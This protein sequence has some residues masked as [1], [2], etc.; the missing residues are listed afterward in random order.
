MLHFASRLPLSRV[1]LTVACASALPACA[2]QNLQDY[3]QEDD[4]PYAAVC[5]KAQSERN[6]AVAEKTYLQPMFHAHVWNTEPAPNADQRLHENAVLKAL[7]DGRVK[8]AFVQAR[9]GIGKTEFAR[10]LAASECRDLP[11]FLLDFKE[12]AKAGGTEQA[13]VQ[14]IA[15]QTG[16]AP[17]D[18]FKLLNQFLLKERFLLIVDSLDEVSPGQ[19]APVLS[20][21]VNLR[22]QF[23]GAQ[24]VL[25][26][27]PA[28]YE[29]Y[30]G[31]AG[32][33]AF[34]E[35]DPLDCTKAMSAFSLYVKDAEASKRVYGFVKAWGLDREGR[36]GDRCYH[37]FLSTYRDLQA[38]TRMAEKFDESKDEMG[39]I[40]FSTTQVHEEILAER[41]KKELGEL[42]MSPADLWKT[43]DNILNKDGFVGGEWNLAMTIQRCLAAQPGGDNGRNR[44]LCEELFQSVLFERVGGNLGSVAEAEW[45]FG[46]QAQADLFTSRWL[47]AEL[48]KQNGNCAMLDAHSVMFDGSK[49][50]AGYLVGRPHGG[51]CLAK[52]AQLLCKAKP[53]AKKLHVKQLYRGL[54]PGDARRPLVSA[55]KEAAAKS[56]PDSCTVDVLGAL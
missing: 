23:A 33:D 37:P 1:A 46:N 13:V 54:P 31:I 39:G 30:Y 25:L 40:Q 3:V 7:R 17:G 53:D 27:R 22:K 24:I 19:R 34:L 2:A 8:T 51:K 20:A 45:K 43:V 48:G 26:G 36:A 49:E 16:A 47:D 41:V 6:R 52:V 35:L 38:I 11:S 4:R 15:K 32:F 42:G 29:T 14:L 5:N 44:Q 9:G 10:A 18:D 55:A 56:T 21:L 12:I 50:V 28:I